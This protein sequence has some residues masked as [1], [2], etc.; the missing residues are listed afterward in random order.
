ML[1]G[2]AHFSSVSFS[3]F[4]VGKLC[5]NFITMKTLTEVAELSAGREHFVPKDLRLYFHANLGS[6]LDQLYTGTIN[7]SMSLL[8]YQN[9]HFQAVP[10]KEW[11][12]TFGG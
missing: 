3:S 8:T 12:K 1:I 6:Q 7:S 10:W 5:L 2:M 9:E 4:Q 11:A